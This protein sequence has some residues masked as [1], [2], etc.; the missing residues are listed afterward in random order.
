MNCDQCS[1]YQSNV[2]QISL[3]SRKTDI[4]Q[5]T[6]ASGD[7]EVDKTILSG[8]TI[9]PGLGN[10]VKYRTQARKAKISRTMDLLWI[11]FLKFSDR[12]SHFRT[13][14]HY[15]Y[16]VNDTNRLPL[17]FVKTWYSTCNMCVLKR[18]PDQFE[19]L[20]RPRE[21]LFDRQLTRGL[22]RDSILSRMGSVSSGVC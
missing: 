19:K 11:D 16:R 9:T 14:V 6:G 22:A 5:V 17:K 10:M 18:F 15:I 21:D 4:T 12:A 8:A 20:S 3:N 7:W 1:I 2:D 13:C